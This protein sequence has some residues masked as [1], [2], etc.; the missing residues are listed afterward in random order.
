M[1]EFIRT[2]KKWMQVVLV[3]LILPSF[4]LFG[5]ETG[6]S[7]PGA[8]EVAVV[9]DTKITQQ[10]WEDAQ[11]RQV[12]YYRQVM[13]DRFDPKMLETPEAKKDILDSLVTQ[14][15]IE[16]E[17][18]A[19]HMTSGDTAVM[20]AI[21]KQG[22]FTK[23]DGSFDVE[24]Y[25]AAL[26]AQG[27]NAIS[28]QENVRRDLASQQLG[29]SIAGTAF[30]PRTVAAR[31]SQISEQEREVQELLL[32][33]AEYESQVKL[34]D[35]MVKAYYDKN[36]ALFQ[37]PEQ[38]K[39]E[40]V[41]FD[42]AVVESQVTVS[43]AEVAEYYNA[44]KNVFTTPEQ[45]KLSHI[46]I[47]APAT[48]SAAE[49]AAAK[50]KAEAIMAE[51]RKD[52]SSFAAV[53]KAQ[54]QDPSSAEQGGDLGIVEKDA[55]PA[56]VEAAALK[57]APG[58]ISDVVASD[59]GY[60]V[61][62]VTELTP[63]AVKPL[64][65]AKPQIMADL[66]RGKMS[67]KY[68]E[69]AEIFNNTVEDQFNSLKPVADQLK[70]QIQTAEG[71]TRTPSPALGDAPVNNPKF[72][73][74]LFADDALKAKRNT[75]AIE[76]GGS[77][78]IAGRVVDYKPASKR[79]L[80]EVEASIRPAVIKEEALR[81][82]K[83]AGE[84]KLAAAKASKDATGF[85]EPKVV[86]RGKPSPL[87]PAATQA[88]MKVDATQLPAYVGVEMPGLGYGV[89]RISKVS[90]AATPDLARRAAEAEQIT[91]IVAQQEAQ[92]YID[93]LKA[94]HEVKVVVKPAAANPQ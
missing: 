94:K 45:R 92:S 58:Q 61:L 66:K 52:P 49:K 27:T 30:V 85:S 75:R 68:S 1:F 12:D 81:M 46:L 11:R 48:A 83:A 86:A 90:Q 36:A 34:T 41:V 72:L 40:Y 63:A 69:L 89:Y 78:L 22:G 23:P 56:P 59:F 57:L 38:A 15:V 82:A 3:L 29:S 70:L 10:Q 14:R 28:Y 33:V 39:V 53:A 77:T 65:E 32:P 87:P 42:P 2:H 44:N 76:I 51:V 62:T 54:S 31:L 19:S 35:A 73:A 79:P 17:T 16:V 67:K 50:A 5:I 74:A 8:D 80:A 18:R 93:A 43:D 9:G 71:I 55:L 84:A 21:A 64:E 7:G 6:N 13:G 37:I 91:S 47:T 4:V 20:Q 24:Q 88:V 25:K 26:K 60:H